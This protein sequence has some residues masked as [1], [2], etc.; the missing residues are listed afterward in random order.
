MNISNGIKKVILV[1]LPS[2]GALGYYRGNRQYNFE[3]NNDIEKYN[4]R[5]IAYDENVEYSKKNN[6][7]PYLDK[8]CKPNKFFIT[9]VFYGL[10][11]SIFYILPLT[12]CAC[13]VKEIYRAEINLSNLEEEKKTRYYNTVYL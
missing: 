12:G 1:A 3:Y 13:L 8:P 5:I 6:R 9:S 4:K 10:Y 11:G 2:W 7:E